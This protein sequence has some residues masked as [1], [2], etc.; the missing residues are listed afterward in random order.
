MSKALAKSH[1][2]GFESP[3]I[4]ALLTTKRNNYLLNLTLMVNPC[5]LEE[6]LWPTM[7]IP[8]PCYT[9]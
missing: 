5:P 4:I 6:A 2:K 1:A 3:D 8:L 9:P 7:R